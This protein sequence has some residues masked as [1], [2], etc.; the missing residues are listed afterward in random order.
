MIRRA[1]LFLLIAI[2]EPAVAVSVE[3]AEPAVQARRHLLGPDDPVAVSVE[4]ADQR[5]LTE[6]APLGA[7]LLHGHPAGQRPEHADRVPPFLR[8]EATVVVA[9]EAFEQNVLELAAGASRLGVRRATEAQGRHECEGCELHVRLTP[10][11]EKR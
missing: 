7:A 5:A 4:P 3:R 8:L 9:I 6:V 10:G 11:G 1:Y 2:V